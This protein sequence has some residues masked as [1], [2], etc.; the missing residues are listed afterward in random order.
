ML[1]AIAGRARRRA[2]AAA[3]TL[4][5]DDGLRMSTL[6]DRLAA[7]HGD[8]PALTVDAPGPYRAWPAATL[9]YAEL[10]AYVDDLAAALRL[11]ADPQPGERVVVATENRADGFLTCLAAMRLG[12]V[13]VPVNP[14][15]RAPEIAHVC[16][17]SEASVVV[18]DRAVFRDGLGERRDAAGP[19][20][21][22]GTRRWVFAD[23]GPAPA[24]M[25]SL[26][27]AL[28]GSGRVAA[29]R[30]DP[31]DVAAILYTSGTTG[32]P[33]GAELTSAAL[34]RQTRLA[35]LGLT[36]LALPW[37]THRLVTALPTAH[38]MGFVTLL[39]GLAA[40]IEV[41]H[42]RRFAA[43]PVLDLIETRRAT[44]VVG[45]PAMHAALLAAD[46]EA[47]DLS[48]VA[49]WVSAAES[50]PI[51]DIRRLKA[52]GS[53]VTRDGHRVEAAFA[54][55]YGSVE[56]S[57]GAILRVSPPGL[58]P[59]RSRGL[60]GWAIPPYRVRIA[61]PDGRPLPP[62]LRGS[63]PGALQLKGPGVLARYRN[64]PDAT[65]ATIAG[66][67]WLQTGDVAA[68]GPLRTVRFVDREK[69]VVKSGGYS[70]YAAEVEEALREHPD[71]VEAAVVGVDHASHTKQ[72]P[73]AAVV[74]AADAGEIG[75]ATIVAWSRE[76]MAGYKAPRHVLVVDA[77][78]RGPTGKVL[79][80]PLRE[81]LADAVG[82]AAR[83]EAAS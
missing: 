43:A 69:D 31:G 1:V 35:S 9:T 20:P 56:L 75:G 32:R 33:K 58:D 64:A 38:V 74:L 46:P 28:T 73:A 36:R 26:D 78:E 53:L 77:L 22:T 34:A 68:W 25:V 62:G 21:A 23:T 15:I 3:R 13:A 24:G 40:G 49:L 7:T 5:G 80:G 30:G 48:S 12:A 42:Q 83:R 65:A 51:G 72:V 60:F 45:V 29:H 47:H 63:D 39:L 44:V 61:G 57:G 52:L 76:R 2:A 55:V 67:G 50:M 10:A 4:V 41:L 11:A 54:D 18:V 70:V 16:A 8:R 17:E 19:P 59:A 66:G 14:Q 37:R 79:K 27:R 81:L 71:V 6:A 82:A